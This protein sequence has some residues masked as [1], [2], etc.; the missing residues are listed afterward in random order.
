MMGIGTHFGRNGADVL[1]PPASPVTPL[2]DAAERPSERPAR[3]AHV[4]H[5]DETSAATR[6]VGASRADP[7]SP[8]SV[9]GIPRHLFDALERR[10]D[11]VGRIDARLS[12][13][14]AA[15]VA[16]ATF[17]PSRAAWIERYFKNTRAFRWQ[18][19]ASRQELGRLGRSFDIVVQVY[20]LF[21]T[22][23]APYVIYVDNTHEISVREWPEWNPLRGRELQRWYAL[24]RE[25]YQ[26][27]LHVF[28]TSEPIARS[29]TGFYGVPADRVS[30][31]GAGANVEALPPLPDRK[32]G[33][34][35]ILFVGREY[36]RKGG[37]VLVDAFRRVR[38]SFPTA[39]L[40]IVGTTDAPREPGVE[41]IGSI[42]D[43][44]H[45]ARL[46]ARASVF[47]LPSRFDPYPGVLAEAMAHALPCVSTSTCGIPEIVVKGE[48][49]LLVP[50]D[51]SDALASALLRL[52]EDPVYRDRLGAAGR[53]RVERHL[54]WDLVVDRMS[55][56]LDHVG[57]DGP[58]EARPT[59][60]APS[61]G[62]RWRR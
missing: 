9:S 33:E 25:T 57:E 36:R 32:A 30:V 1:A 34:P 46:Y 35:I 16:L 13:G 61:G 24:E 2:A 55:N 29:V 48:T 52:L 28:V 7:Y 20:G 39:R 31:V 40:Q 10:Y 62:R 53:R 6:I 38:A 44:G 51:D 3:Q 22:L 54:T 21:R 45:L 19:D 49:G 12:A 14:R 42:S 26:G 4:C 37:D 8:L 47:C 56:V 18:S 50:R 41:V 60:D 5:R 23:G 17:A 58:D 43:R 59:P 11:M 27:A 15:L